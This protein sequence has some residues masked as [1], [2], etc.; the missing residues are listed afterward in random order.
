MFKSKIKW[1]ALGGLVLS[2]LSLLVHMFLANTS[3]DLVQ[4]HVMTGFVEDLNINVLGKQV[5]LVLVLNFSRCICTVNLN[6][7]IQT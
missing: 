6:C 4:Y 3:A 1:V 2:F 5:I 7:G